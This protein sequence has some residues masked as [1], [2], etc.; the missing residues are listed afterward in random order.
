MNHALNILTTS[1]GGGYSENFLFIVFCILLSDI[2]TNACQRDMQIMDLK[3][4]V[5]FEV[6]VLRP[7]EEY[8]FVL[9]VSETSFDS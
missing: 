2:H 1:A 4:K 8:L 6:R 3:Y 7:L 9:L 5:Y